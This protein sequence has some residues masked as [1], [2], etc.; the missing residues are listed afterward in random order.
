MDKP[1]QYFSITRERR[2][3]DSTDRVRIRLVLAGEFD[4]AARDALEGALAS[5]L[6]AGDVEI[7]MG[8]VTFLDCSGIG[9]LTRGLRRAWREGRGLHVVN[10][11]G[12]VRHMLELTGVAQELTVLE[13]AHRPAAARQRRAKA[14]GRVH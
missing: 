10:A 8:E 13:S 3:E 1:R 7:D 11:D 6:R 9:V 5:A 2:R 14:N 12:S 4:L